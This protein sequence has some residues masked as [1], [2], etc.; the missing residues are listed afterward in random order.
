MYSHEYTRHVR[1]N[2]IGAMSAGGGW[3]FTLMASG[4]T[5]CRSRMKPRIAQWISQTVST[6][7]RQNPGI[8]PVFGTIVINGH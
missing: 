2:K 5:S 1:M 4:D 8:I 6:M 3:D 7:I